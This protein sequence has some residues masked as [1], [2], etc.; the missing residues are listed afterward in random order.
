ML[1]N[2]LL[3]LNNFSIKKLLIKLINN[4]QNKLILNLYTKLFY[5]TT[6]HNNLLKT[7]N[8]KF[9]SNTSKNKIHNFIINTNKT[10]S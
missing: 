10:L 2:K 9:L 3:K 8:L 1:I 6:T 5:S 7:N 4:T